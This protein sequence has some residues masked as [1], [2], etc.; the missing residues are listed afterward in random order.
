MNDAYNLLVVRARILQVTDQRVKIMSE[1]IQSMGIVKMYCW[2][3]AF[4]KKVRLI[5]K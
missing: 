3:S 5:R 4:V 1:I 2:E